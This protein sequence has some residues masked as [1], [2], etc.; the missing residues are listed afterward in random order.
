MRERRARIVGWLS[1]RTEA[2][3]VTGLCETWVRDLV[4]GVS[5][6]RDM[7]FPTCRRN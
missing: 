1:Q 3:I 4:G 7:I 2:K 6:V 5:P